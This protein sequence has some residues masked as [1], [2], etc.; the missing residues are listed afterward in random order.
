MVLRK[1]V[2]CLLAGLVMLTACRKAVPGGDFQAGM[3]AYADG[4]YKTSMQ[5]WRPLADAGDPA[6]QTNVGFLYYQGQGV[7]QSYEEALKWYRMAALTG[8]PDAAF[9]LGVAYSEGKGVKAD[10]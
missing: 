9:D 6:A 8:Y 5:K 4:D 1:I 2:W 7:P 10:Q 3:A